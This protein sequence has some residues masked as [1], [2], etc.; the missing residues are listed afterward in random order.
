MYRL[1]QVT[2]FLIFIFTFNSFAQNGLSSNNMT[3]VNNI[4][5]GSKIAQSQLGVTIKE[6]GRGEVNSVNSSNIEGS[7]YLFKNWTNLATV[8]FKDKVFQ[9]ESVNFNL[10]Y[11]KF[12]IKISNDSIFII[13][14]PNVK[15][16]RINN[17]LFK[18]IV[19]PE[20][21]KRSFFE[22]IWASD[23]F[24]LLSKYELKISQGA[25]D[26]L[27]KAYIKPKEY[28]SKKTYYLLNNVDET[29]TPFK[30]K[31]REVLKLI[32]ASY[33]EDVKNFV[34]DRKLK[35]SKMPDVKIILTYYNSIKNKM[36]G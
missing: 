30:L 7:P 5:V 2:S 24:D 34:K 13:N 18:Q 25:I 14:S 31:K 26:P 15:K 36:K 11:E 10:Q 27:T 21:Q 16:V 28:F 20:N 4:A 9:L 3:G 29:L 22:E 35:Y 8:W 12:E 19:N 23:K 17:I 1:L 6:F 33:L 32:D